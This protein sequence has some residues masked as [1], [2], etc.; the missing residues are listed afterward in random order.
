[1]AKP[2]LIL[3]VTDQQRAPQHWP[4]G[5]EWLDQ[6]TPNDAELRRTGVSF[7]RA[8]IASSMC[9]P[10]RASLLTGTY[11]AR[12]GV[13]LTLTKGDLFPDRRNAPDVVRTA[14]R[15]WRSGEVPRE[16][17]ARGFARGLLR[18][19]PKSGNEP[20]L[21]PGTGTLATHLRERGYHVALKGK[22]H[23]TQAGA[24]RVEPRRQRAHRARLRLRRLGAARRR[25]RRQGGELRRR[26][27]GLD[28]PRLGRG[29][30][31]P[32]RALARPGRRCPSRSAW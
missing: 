4:G 1:M 30:H 29:L 24:R 6:L 25:R 11:P 14:A 17:I 13:T 16:R 31:A 9:S 8:F 26:L 20:E 23:L 5:A 2:N 22:W 3:L 21:T 19:G 15:L 10:S 27:R 12:H 18:L 28:R 32:G 7:T